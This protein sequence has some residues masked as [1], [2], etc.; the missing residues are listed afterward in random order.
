[1]IPEV[2]KR[3]IEISGELV[4][5]NDKNI[6]EL[7]KIILNLFKG[8]SQDE[9][10]DMIKNK[11]KDTIFF[12]YKLFKENKSLQEIDRAYLDYYINKNKPKKY[13]WYRYTGKITEK[14]FKRIKEIFQRDS[15]LTAD[16]HLFNNIDDPTQEGYDLAEDSIFESLDQ[17]FRI[18]LYYMVWVDFDILLIGSSKFQYLIDRIKK[19]MERK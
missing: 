18:I 15:R 11:I 6:E 9:I 8:I 7:K 12:L 3:I 17:D 2:E 14:R 16:Y 19:I 4:E 13:I 10:E 1:M 5:G